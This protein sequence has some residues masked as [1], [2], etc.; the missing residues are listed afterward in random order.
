MDMMLTSEF[1]A[2]TVREDHTGNGSR[3][4]V[5]DL[6]TGHER[7][8]DPLQLETLAWC[9]EEDMEILADPSRSRWLG[10]PPTADA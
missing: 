10:R 8:F 3:L 1:A 6:K 4:V 7:Y 5:R 9:S 2:V